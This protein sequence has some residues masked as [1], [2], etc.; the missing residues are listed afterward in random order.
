MCGICGLVRFPNTN[1]KDLDLLRRVNARLAHRGP[2]DEGHWSEGP[3]A[4]AMRRLAVID[5]RTGHQPMA[6][7]TGELRLVFNGEVYNFRELRRGLE[8]RGHRFASQSD[9]ET[10]LHL[11]EEHGTQAATHLN[12][13]FALALWDGPRR[14]LWLCRDPLGIKPLYYAWVEGAFWFA[15]EVQALTELP[16]LDRALDPL[17]LEQY[18]ALRYVPAPRS[19]FQA[20]R[21]VPTGHSLLVEESGSDLRPYWR[22]ALRPEGR[23]G[24]GIEE[25]SAALR[26]A[27]GAAVVRQMVSDVPLGAFLSGGLDSSAVVAFMAGA[28]RQPVRTFCVAFRGWPGLDET[29]HARRVARYLGTA[30]R[31][32]EVEL[33]V[34]GLL[35]E[36][37]AASG[38]PLADPAA[39]PT[40]AMARAAR[41]EV[42]VALTGE[43]ADE[44][45]GGY[46]WY[47]WATRPALPLPQAVQQFLLRGVQHLWRGQRGS[48]TLQSYLVADAWTRY[49]DLVASSTFQEAEREEIRGPCLWEALGGR[50]LWEHTFQPLLEGMKGLDG[51]SQF[52]FLDLS[53]WLEGDPLAKVDRM[54]MAASLEARVPFLDR[55]V[56]ELAAA[57]PPEVKVR[58]PTSKLV[59][60]E[61]MRGLLPPE[62]LNRAKHAF[63]PPVAGW[64]RGPLR[65]ALQR[66]PRHPAVAESGYL[67]PNAVARRV[68]EH[69]AGRDHHRGL[70]AVLVFAV[71]WDHYGG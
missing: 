11:Y 70:W 63:D 53:V 31:E 2:D 61:A 35:R 40:L 7:E 34:P 30:H 55:E 43:G 20:V 24:W 12:G 69:L 27:L 41:E 28:S 51:L 14:R 16:A 56:L 26:A 25:W 48:R 9:A 22:L 5:L 6:N 52:Q 15:S 67:N 23:P 50:R 47:R 38:E 18:L 29:P 39:L 60:R 1:P 13:M 37:V 44:L 45:L 46:G 42:T 17:A 8:K 49:A 64:L 54:T 33:D 59:L 19:I 58:G 65:E 32:I 71:W 66:L 62:I 3:A 21:K 4:L 57:M 36:S 10:V 68:Q